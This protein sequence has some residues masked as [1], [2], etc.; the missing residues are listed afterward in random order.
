MNVTESDKKERAKNGDGGWWMDG[1]KSI[2]GVERSERILE[3]I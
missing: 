1:M 3:M 2:T